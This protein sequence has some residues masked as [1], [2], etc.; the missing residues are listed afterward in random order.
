MSCGNNCTGCRCGKS[1]K[2]PE[3][4]NAYY[5]GVVDGVLCYAWWKDGTQ[6]V[7][8]TGKTFQSALKEI[9]SERAEML[10]RTK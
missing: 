9:E 8:T 6:M 3:E 10:E 1:I 7:G 4:I 2:T 5:D